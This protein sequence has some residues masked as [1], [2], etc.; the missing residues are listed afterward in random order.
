MFLDVKIVGLRFVFGLDLVFWGLKTW[1]SGRASRRFVVLEVK[2]TW[3]SG[4]ASRRFV[5][6][7][8]KKTW[9]SGRASRRFVVLEVKKLG[10]Q[11]ALRVDFWFW[12]SK[13][14]VIR[15]RFV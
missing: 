7:E 5:V 8:V 10:H 6:L 9:S 4:R 2:K 1:S 11:V 3:S 15:S 12:S 13:N 14:W